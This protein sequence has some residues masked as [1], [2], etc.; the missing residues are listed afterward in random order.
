MSVSQADSETSIGDDTLQVEYGEDDR[1]I[2]GDSHEI[3]QHHA[4]AGNRDHLAHSCPAGID[5][6]I[7]GSLD[8][9][10]FSTEPDI[11]LLSSAHPQD[12][13]DGSIRPEVAHVLSSTTD[14]VLELQMSSRKDLK[15]KELE[16][17]ERRRENFTIVCPD[18]D[19]YRACPAGSQNCSCIMCEIEAVLGWGVREKIDSTD[20]GSCC[21]KRSSSQAE[22]ASGTHSG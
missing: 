1:E 4:I 2:P 14:I 19:E 22:I 3:P 16:D 15:R 18:E 9:D 13:E 21:Q 10:V 17:L 6:S 11:D 20:V 12:A 8:F 5:I 7:I